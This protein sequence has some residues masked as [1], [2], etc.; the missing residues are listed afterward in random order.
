M[1]IDKLK[2]VV[3]DALDDLK[4]KDVVVIDVSEQS[5]V[6]DF[7]VI[8]SGSSSRQVKSLAENV[9]LKAKEQGLDSIGTEGED[10]GE[11]VLVDLGDIVVH[12]MQEPVRKFY[13]LERLWEISEPKQGTM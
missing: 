8:A 1:Q 2:E 9:R 13:Q 11:W 6:T 4:A 10:I 5:D 3:V 12:V 7:M